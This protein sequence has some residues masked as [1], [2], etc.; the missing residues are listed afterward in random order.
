M[1]Q[2]T[3]AASCEQLHLIYSSDIQ[4]KKE[5]AKGTAPRKRDY[6]GTAT[7]NE[8]TTRA[9]FF[10]QSYEQRGSQPA[11]PG[12]LMPASESSLPPLESFLS[13]ARLQEQHLFRAQHHARTRAKTMTMTNSSTPPPPWTC[14]TV[15][16]KIPAADDL[17]CPDDSPVAVVTVGESTATSRG[18]HMLR[19]HFDS[20][21][22]SNPRT[23]HFCAAGE[24]R[25]VQGSPPPERV[26][27]SGLPPPP[28]ARPPPPPPAC[29]GLLSAAPSLLLRLGGAAE[30]R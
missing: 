24:V 16:T 23:H 26:C 22:S 30:S 10:I 15:K 4:S 9:A 3:S 25:D 29:P 6:T 11:V 21:F 2:I 18:P 13:K 17:S 7:A 8:R 1:R 14:S 19:Q 5:K 20:L 27:P 12:A 28:L